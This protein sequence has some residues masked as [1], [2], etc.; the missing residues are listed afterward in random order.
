[1]WRSR[2]DSSDFSEQWPT[3]NSEPHTSR[4]RHKDD[5]IIHY[6]TLKSY[7]RIA[8]LA[9]VTNCI[10]TLTHAM[11]IRVAREGASMCMDGKAALLV[12]NLDVQREEN[13][14]C[15]STARAS[16]E[17]REHAAGIRRPLRTDMYRAIGGK[18]MLS[19]KG[20]RYR[21]KR[22]SSGNE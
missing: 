9:P 6:C 4:D 2:L 18:V 10:S 17:R 15:G 8:T 12:M 19:C 1:M 3:R 11:Y 13:E 22:D 21:A 7:I 16:S 5:L 20:Q 14:L